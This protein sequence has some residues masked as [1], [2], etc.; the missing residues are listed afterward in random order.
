MKRHRFMVDLLRPTLASDLETYGIN[1]H[2]L[3]A[4]DLDE[5]IENAQRVIE[6]AKLRKQTI[7]NS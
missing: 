6:A 5:I 3:T 4:K 1:Q 2:E 7:A